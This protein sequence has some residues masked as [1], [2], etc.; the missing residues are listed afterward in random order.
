MTEIEQLT[1]WRNYQ[2]HALERARTASSEPERQA[3]YEIARIT[4][5]AIVNL[6]RLH[7]ERQRI[8]AERLAVCS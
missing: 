2:L 5:G 3:L 8:E 4:S 6:T 7:A 1:W